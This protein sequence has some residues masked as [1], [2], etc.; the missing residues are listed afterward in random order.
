MYSSC[1]KLHLRQ[2]PSSFD[3]FQKS[4]LLYAKTQAIQRLFSVTLLWKLQKKTNAGPTSATG[5][6]LRWSKLTVKGC[7]EILGPSYGEVV[8]LW[9]LWRSESRTTIC[10]QWKQ[11][12]SVASTECQPLLS[13]QQIQS[14]VGTT[15]LQTESDT[16]QLVNRQVT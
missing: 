1:N 3:H 6:Q 2:T 13:M 15:I 16:K 9:L 8:N 10:A 14:I 11:K 5:R 7:K 12:S 4:F